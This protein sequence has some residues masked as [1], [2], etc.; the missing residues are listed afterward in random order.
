MARPKQRLE[1][2]VKLAVPDAK[3]GR[4]I[5]REAGFSAARRRFFEANTIS[6]PP[7]GRLRRGRHL[8]RLRDAGGHHIIALKNAPLKSRF[9]SRE[10]IET[11]SGDPAAMTDILKRLG[12][13]P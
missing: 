7:E 11:P 4:P 5:L 13:E 3:G 8:L 12:Y 2:E 1:I 10:E 9:K 6:D